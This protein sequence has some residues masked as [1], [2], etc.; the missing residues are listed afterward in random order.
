MPR[1]VT[2]GVIFAG[3][4]GSRLRP[5]TDHV[6]KPLL[7][8]AGVPVIDTVLR[9][10]EDAG[11]ETVTLVTGYLGQHLR[12]HVRASDTPLEVS[13]AHQ[14]EQLGSA[15]SL[16]CA[17]EQ[18]MVPQ[19][20]VVIAGDTVWQRGDIGRITD[21]FR[22]GTADVTMGVRRWPISELPHRSVV[23][24]D[25]QGNV[26][27]IVAAPDPAALASDSAFAGSPVY[28]FGA[29]FWERVSAVEP[30]Q[31][32]GLYELAVALQ[33]LIDA[34]GT[35]QPIEVRDTVDITYPG[36]LLRH[37]FAWLAEIVPPMV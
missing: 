16:Q 22:T 29:A 20:S 36:D 19:N 21:A 15:H 1:Q 13:F 10:L 9:Q 31:P 24:F 26:S 14:D 17:L 8:I 33:A 11:I 7:P 6:P 12:D 18:G 5:L 4:R 3:G 37:N 34:G 30:A 27:R 2:H 28:V 35:V 25:Q 32:S 23:A